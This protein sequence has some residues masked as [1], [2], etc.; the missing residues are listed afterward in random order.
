MNIKEAIEVAG[1][2]VQGDGEE[3]RICCPFCIEEGELSLDERFRLGINT[4][5]GAGHCFNCGKKG[6]GEWMLSELQRVLDTGEMELAEEKRKHK[7]KHK[8]NKVM[9][10]EGFELLDNSGYWGKKAWSYVRKRGV[11]EKQIKNKGIGYTTIGPMAYRII[12]PVYRHNKLIGLVGRDFLGTNP[13]KYL[14]S[15]GDKAIYNLPD[16]THH[17]SICL[18]EGVF[19]ALSIERGSLKLGIDSG[20]LL[21]HALKDEQLELLQSMGYKYVYLW[22][23]PDN[24]GVKG[25]MTIADKLMPIFKVLVVLPEGFKNT[26]RDDIDLDPGE[27]EGKIVVKKLS[28]TRKCTTELLQQ[29]RAWQAFDE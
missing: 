10:P 4:R 19:D 6:Y 14:N 24:A 27:L 23:D 11:T 12:F 22:L 5:T 20:A 7:S 17:K 26:D 16:S 2:E 18:S 9:L 8:R 1:V 28:H 21:G 29:L 25:T 13:I 15:V 3:I